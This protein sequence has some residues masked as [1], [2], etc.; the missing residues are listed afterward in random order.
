MFLSPFQFP[1]TS[2][3]FLAAEAEAVKLGAVYLAFRYEHGPDAEGAAA[4]RDAYRAATAKAA[5]L[6]VPSR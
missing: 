4:L 1:P 6:R 3:E 5:A 2:P